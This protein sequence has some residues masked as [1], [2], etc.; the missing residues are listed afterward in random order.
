M[1]RV[2]R[3]WPFRVVVVVLAGIVLYRTCYTLLPSTADSVSVTV[4]LYASP[5]AYSLVPDASTTTLF[6]RTFTDEATVSGVRA[7]LDGMHYVGAFDHVGCNGGF[8]AT[9]D[10]FVNLLWHGSAVKSYEAL[11]DASG[12]RC[13]WRVTTLGVQQ[14]ATERATTWTDVVRLTGMPVVPTAAP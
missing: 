9:R 1:R 14:V 10:Y 2:L 3:S 6:Q 12:F 5:P 13:F 4:V 11:G 8:S 7:T